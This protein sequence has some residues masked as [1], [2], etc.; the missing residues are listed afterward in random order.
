MIRER[1]ETAR[2]LVTSKDLALSTVRLQP[3]SFRRPGSFSQTRSQSRERRLSVSFQA[4]NVPTL[5]YHNLG[6]V[7]TAFDEL[8]RDRAMT[9]YGSIPLSATSRVIVLYSS[10]AGTAEILVR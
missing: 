9:V 1:V 3:S 6:F 10:A 2:R 7:P 8:N 5:V 4:A